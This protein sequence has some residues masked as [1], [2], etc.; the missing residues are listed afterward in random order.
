MSRLRLLRLGFWCVVGIV[1]FLALVPAEES[2]RGLPTD[3]LN[4]MLA[5]FVLAILARVLWPGS[6]ALR[7]LLLLGCF[8]SAIEL[9]QLAM[10]LGRTAEWGDLAAD[11]FGTLAG[12]LCGRFLLIFRNRKMPA[13]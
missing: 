5:F 7:L 2:V 13:N 3:K 10:A 12:L 1:L 11:V 6:G 4:H 8:G 9:L